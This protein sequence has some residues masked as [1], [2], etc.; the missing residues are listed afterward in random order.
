[1]SELSPEAITI[2][3]LVVICLGVMS[4][5]PLAFVIGAAALVFGYPVYG[6]L[7]GELMYTRIWSL[8][9]NYT[10]L[11]LPLFVFMGLMLE[12]SGMAERLY[13]VLYL[14]LGGLR[15]GLAMVTIL[16]GTIMAA[17]VGIITASVTMLTLV[18]L[19][20][21]LKR[22]YSKDLATGSICAGGCL[23]ILIPPSIML[24][25][26]GPM[27]EISVGKLFFGAFVPGFLLSSLYI[28]YIAFRSLL[29]PKAAPSVPIEDRN[30]PFVKK[31]ALLLMALGPP[32]LLIL[33]VLGTIFFGIAPPTE[34]AGVGAFASILLAIG[35]RRFSWTVLREVTL[36]TM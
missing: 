32:G 19:P 9:S 29:Q 35:Y 16:I 2:L 6:N 36:L 23:G 1:M 18:A 27:A 24:V 25:I 33:A 21:M 4:G 5:F 11:A 17:C 7:I 3:M 13:D 20:S 12:R 31:T 8:L 22:G 34:A 28:T 10:L 15:G 30:I 26:Y 14:W